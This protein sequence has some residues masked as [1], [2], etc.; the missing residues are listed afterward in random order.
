MEEDDTYRV[1]VND[2]PVSTKKAL[3]SRLERLSSQHTPP[4]ERGSASISPGQRE[5]QDFVTA[6]FP[7]KT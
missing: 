3:N 1:F 5:Q 6:N 4:K 7:Q 2:D